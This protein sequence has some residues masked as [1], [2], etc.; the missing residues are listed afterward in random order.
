MI[1]NWYYQDKYLENGNI[2]EKT[3]STFSSSL[4]FQKHILGQILA[5]QNYES[6]VE[7]YFSVKD[8]DWQI[9]KENPVS[10]STR[11]GFKANIPSIK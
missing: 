4:E 8:K 3:I 6:Y 11:L 5:K 1:L 9:W 7:N 10:Q 2:L